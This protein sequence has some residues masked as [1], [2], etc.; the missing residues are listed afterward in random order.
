[1]N[2]S[3]IGETVISNMAVALIV[4]VGGF[5]IWRWQTI[6]R[7]RFD[8]AEEA[9][10]LF[11]QAE[12]QFF[13][14]RR[15]NTSTIDGQKYFLDESYSPEERDD[16]KAA[17]HV[18][19]ALH[20]AA[21]IRGELISFSRLCR[22]HL[23]SSAEAALLTLDKAFEDLHLA[24]IE[25]DIFTGHRREGE[26]IEQHEMRKRDRSAAKAKLFGNKSTRHLWDYTFDDPLSKQVIEA[27]DRLAAISA[28]YHD[29]NIFRQMIRFPKK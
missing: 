5:F 16:E 24:Y 29:V 21:D 7:R 17:E 28:K 18:L 11:A 12:A 14:A 6:F 20:E 22:F 1:M 4:A 10:K 25:F 8:V 23:G 15:F 3:R 9:L 19:R 13:K 2:W 26:T 27:R